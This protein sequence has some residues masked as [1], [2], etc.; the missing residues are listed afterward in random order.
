[1]EEIPG[2]LRKVWGINNSH[3]W[4]G[5]A[6][7]GFGQGYP[8]NSGCLDIHVQSKCSGLR[9]A[10]AGEPR[11]ILPHHDN[12]RAYQDKK[13]KKNV[14]LAEN[15]VKLTVTCVK[16]NY[17]PAVD[18][19]CVTQ[20]DW[21]KRQPGGDPVGSSW[22]QITMAWAAAKSRDSATTRP[23]DT[24]RAAHGHST[25]ALSTRLS[26]SLSL[27]LSRSLCTQVSRKGLQYTLLATSLYNSCPAPKIESSNSTHCF[28]CGCEK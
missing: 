23:T 25:H 12:S 8:Q 7:F 15:T 5:D 17:R 1:M 28:I 26:L 3:R 24:P 13:N 21:R 22:A 18:A 20:G 9:A 14:H 6:P 10:T 4:L 11:Y 27:S 19:L 2:T 16:F